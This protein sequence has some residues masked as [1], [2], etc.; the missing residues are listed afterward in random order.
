[1]LSALWKR[2]AR[3]SGRPDVPALP[4][5]VE[6]ACGK[7]LAGERSHRPQT[8]RCP[9]CG[10]KVFVF[11]SS[12]LAQLRETII[13]SLRQDAAKAAPPARPRPNLRRPLLAAGATLLAVAAGFLVLFNGPWF[14]G[15][16]A[17][18]KT[19]GPDEALIHEESAAGRRAAAE[20]AFAEAAAHFQRARA[21]AEK[22]SGDEARKNAL[23]QLEAEAALMGDLLSESLPEVLQRA[24]G[25]GERAWADL[26]RQR[27]RGRALVFDATVHAV[28][29]GAFRIDYPVLVPGG[30]ARVEIHGSN[31][32]RALA[33]AWPARL[34]VGVRLAEARRDARGNWLV[35][36]R[37][38][39]V[40]FTEPAMFRGSSV[41]VDAEFAD[42]LR[43]QSRLL[44]VAADAGQ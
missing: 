31:E 11:P 42:A 14:R 10:A 1:M 30:T 25:L 13:A 21:E 5:R 43:N 3:R 39:I 16:H 2:V 26:F 24:K 38:D 33:V 40:L 32:L 22:S 29:G 28:G 34:V 15:A 20:G 4:Y 27:Y 35:L 8:R 12:P 37:P 9:G 17:P 36:A 23:A 6:C 44:G 41:P 7:V 19:S 18:G